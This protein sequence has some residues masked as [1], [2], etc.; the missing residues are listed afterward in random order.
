[1][2]KRLLSRYSGRLKRTQLILNYR[3]LLRIFIMARKRMIHPSIWESAYDKGWNTEDLA[4]MVAAISAA[5]DEGRGRV[6]V[7]LR[8]LG[9]MI[10]EKKFKKSIQKLSDS[11]Q[12][13]EKIYYF[14]PNWYEYQSISK[15]QPS[16][17]PKPNPLFYNDLTKNSNGMVPGTVP[18]EVRND[19]DLSKINVSKINLNKVSSKQTEEENQGSLPL[20]PL[21]DSD[22]P[23]LTSYE[24][25]APKTFDDTNHVRN[26]IEALIKAFC[27]INPKKEE[28]TRFYNIITNTKQV[29]KNT[30][31]KFTFDCVSA[32][33]KLPADKQNLAYLS[34]QVEG[35]I[36]DAKE[37]KLKELDKVK[38]L[39]GGNP[40]IESVIESFSIDK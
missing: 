10:S 4:V 18:Q 23:L 20:T 7:I 9:A 22:L 8:N 1:M 15:P 25:Y 40:E 31:F 14:L 35:K 39:P 32:Y 6:S 37:K 27:N 2:L 38:T 21:P 33:S 36:K 13:Y 30:A 34:S 17:I 28:I 5:D 26:K 12:I 11:I 24:D 3:K 16:R 29:N 19:S